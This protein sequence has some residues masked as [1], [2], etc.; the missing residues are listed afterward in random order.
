[1]QNDRNMSLSL[2]KY[3]E[4]FIK[5]IKIYMKLKWNILYITKYSIKIFIFYNYIIFII[6]F[7]NKIKFLFLLRDPFTY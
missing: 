1:M 3:S 7:V 4:K 2:R 5:I 6:Y